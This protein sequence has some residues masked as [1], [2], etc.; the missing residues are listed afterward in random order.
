MIL[1][2]FVWYTS[3]VTSKRP[4]VISKTLEDKSI[5]PVPTPAS[6]KKES[7][8]GKRMPART[9]SE[10]DLALNPEVGYTRSV[11]YRPSNRVIDQHKLLP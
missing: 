1:R 8:A 3:V 5:A 9:I 4:S 2:P 7:A 10:E 6:E 11:N